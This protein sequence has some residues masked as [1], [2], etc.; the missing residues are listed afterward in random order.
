MGTTA[1]KLTYLNGTKRLLRRRLNSLGAEITLETRFRDY[2][3]W[4]DRFYDAASS[5]VD[6]EILGETTQ[7]QHTSLNLL[8][9]NVQTQT[10]N[11]VTITRNDDGTL[12]LNGTATTLTTIMIK[13]NFEL[14][15]GT[16]YFNFYDTTVPTYFSCNYDTNGTTYSIWQNE[17]KTFNN[18]KVGQVYINIP[19][20]VSFNNFVIHPMISEGSTQK[21]YEPYGTKPSPS[22][23]SP[24]VNKTGDI[25]YTASD[26]T[27]F[28]VSLG[29][30][31]LR[32]NTDPNGLPDRIYYKDGKILGE[33][34]I[35]QITLT[36]DGVENWEYSTNDDVYYASLGSEIEFTTS[37]A[38]SNYFKNIQ[39]ASIVDVATAGTN[40]KN[41]EF[42]VIPNTNTLYLKYT[43]L[44]EP[45]PDEALAFMDWL[46][47]HPMKLQYELPEEYMVPMDMKDLPE[48]YQTLYNQLQAIVDYETKLEIEKKIF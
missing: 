10:I 9:N 18:D 44:T 1:E 31:E 34:R 13:D 8:P 6:F 2:L 48:E 12:I 17:A 37:Y 39:D 28:P 46:S 16:Y 7:E 24:I 4:L 40:L 22:N 23:P 5:S 15:A 32:G 25:T 27:E 42:V 14:S 3:V 43:E 33:S 41:G 26:G 30:I 19:E 21:S 20:T 29:D 36:G 45:S 38:L 47:E 11:G 35:N